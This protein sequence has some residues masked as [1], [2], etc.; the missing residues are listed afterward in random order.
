MTIQALQS[1]CLEDSTTLSKWYLKN[2]IEPAQ[3]IR[4]LN[5]N[6]ISF[7]LVGLHGLSAW[8]REP[9]GT[10]DVDVIVAAKHVKKAVRVLLAAFPQLEPVDLEVVTRLKVKDTDDV[11]IDVMKP[12]QYP[13]RSVF[14]NNVEV[15]AKGQTY[16]IPT[17]EMGLALKFAPMISLNR[18]D[19]DKYQDAHDF[20]RMVKNNKDIDLDVLEELGEL[21]YNGGGQ[22]IL[23][24][25][26]R[27]RAGEKLE[28]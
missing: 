16:R 27:V 25:V 6:K 3:V 28:I 17:L 9:R 19:E 1:R 5:A 13:V 2:M 10:K 8:M 12:V 7:V 23:E 18:A 11:L 22:D 14:K 24:L 26:R 4:V 20:I 15:K 21:V